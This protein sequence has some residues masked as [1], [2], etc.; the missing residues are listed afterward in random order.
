MI[1]D[2]ITAKE[3]AD[4]LIKENYKIP[5][6]YSVLSHIDFVNGKIIDAVNI[7]KKAESLFPENIQIKE[8]IKELI[9]ISDGLLQIEDSKYFKRYKEE[10]VKTSIESEKQKNHKLS[11]YDKLSAFCQDIIEKVRKYI[12]M[13]QKTPPIFIK[14][15]IDN[16]NSMK[17]EFFRDEFQ[18]HISYLYDHT[19]AEIQVKE[20]K[21]DLSIKEDSKSSEIIIEFKIW[22]RNDY[23]DCANQLKKYF[24]DENDFGIVFMINTNKSSIVSK[25]R[26]E[27]IYNNSSY[28][29]GTYRDKVFTE[30]KNLNC[31]YSEHTTLTSKKIKVVHF[32]YDF[33][34]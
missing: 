30:Q 13:I 19:N 15:F 14:D 32:I 28:I 33:Y 2:Y 6:P 8:Q 12:N 26:E 11:R 5:G 22:G 20:G 18:R 29:V 34:L 7:L 9:D 25:Y 17:E 27:I 16:K 31:L 24:T 1:K 21:A 10:V 23:K 3:Q 4:F